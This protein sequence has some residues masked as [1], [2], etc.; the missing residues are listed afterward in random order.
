MD[1]NYHDTLDPLKRGDPTSD[2]AGTVVRGQQN[3]V[4]SEMRRHLVK[5]NRDKM[6]ERGTI[7]AKELAI[8]GKYS[9]FTDLATMDFSSET[10]NSSSSSTS[11]NGAASQLWRELL[12]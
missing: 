7:T 3:K 9:S 8:L 5:M 1:N 6:I 12:Y 4:M 2:K 11:S 10:V